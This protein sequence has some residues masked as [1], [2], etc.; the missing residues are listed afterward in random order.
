MEIVRIITENKTNWDKQWDMAEGK[1]KLKDDVESDCF[2]S[3]LF[4]V[5]FQ[6]S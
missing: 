1:K 2:L 6:V 5:G 4:E 3:Y